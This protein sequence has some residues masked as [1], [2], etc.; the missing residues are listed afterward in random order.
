MFHVFSNRARTTFDRLLGIV[1]DSKFTNAVVLEPGDARERCL[2]NTGL[3]YCF[4]F[5][6]SQDDDF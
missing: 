1:S 3:G 4:D 5:W 2:G 6:Q